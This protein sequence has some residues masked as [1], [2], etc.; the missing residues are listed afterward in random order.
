MFVATIWYL[1]PRSCWS[2]QKYAAE[3]MITSPEY[4]IYCKE[5][6]RW[7]TVMKATHDRLKKK[8][9]LTACNL[10]LLNTS[11]SSSI[12]YCNEEIVQTVRKLQRRID[13]FAS[14]ACQTAD[15]CDKSYLTTRRAPAGYFLKFRIGVCRYKGKTKNGVNAGC[16]RVNVT[17]FLKHW[18]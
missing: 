1:S 16:E 3:Q 9:Q 12:V 5:W 4:R 17:P 2:A 18:K 14:F 6:V 7:M 15:I 10:K 8:H 11:V 13:P